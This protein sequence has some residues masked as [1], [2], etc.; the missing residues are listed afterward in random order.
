MATTDPKVV[1]LHWRDHVN[2][3]ERVRL[4]YLDEALAMHEH[5]MR[6]MLVERAKLRNV[7]IQRRMRA[8]ERA[9]ADQADA[10]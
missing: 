3:A 5:L 7:A 9:Q 2:E 1:P 4:A 10:A 6:P 8:V